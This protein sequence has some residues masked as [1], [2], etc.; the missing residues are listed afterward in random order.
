MLGYSKALRS[1]VESPGVEGFCGQMSHRDTKAANSLSFFLCENRCKGSQIK[2][3]LVVK[4]RII[5]TVNDF[6]I[7]LTKMGKSNM[8]LMF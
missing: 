2:A 3:F 5:R 6:S 8:L 1:P 4:Q 7:I